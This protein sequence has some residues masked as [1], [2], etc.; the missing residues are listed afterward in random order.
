VADLVLVEI[1]DAREHLLKV[2]A[3]VLLLEALPLDYVVKQLS[4]VSV[5]HN[6][7]E[8]PVGFDDLIELNDVGVPNYLQNLDLS[9]HALN[10]CLVRDLVLLQD[11]DGHAL[12]CQSVSPQPH[13]PKRSLAQRPSNHIVPDGP[14]FSVVRAGLRQVSLLQC[15]I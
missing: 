10:V 2:A 4:S 11:F 1:L 14:I 8:L 3:S 7:E 13:L 9:R 12:P 6:E 5:L 15:L